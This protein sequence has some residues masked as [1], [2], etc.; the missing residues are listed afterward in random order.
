MNAFKSGQTSFVSV[1]RNQKKTSINVFDLVVGD[2]VVIKG[3]EKVPADI[4]VFRCSGIKV[5]NSPLNGETKP[6]TITTGP[7]EH[8]LKDA[9]EATNMM[10]YSTLIKDGE[11]LGIVIKTGVD[12]FMGKIADLAQSAGDGMTTLQREINDFIHLIAIV[13]VSIGLLFFILGF[14]INYPIITNFLFCIGIIVANVPEGLLSTVTICLVITAKKMQKK[15]VLVKNLQSVETLG[16][17]TCICSDK[18]GTLTQNKMKVVHL[19]YDGKIFKTESYF[20]DIEVDGRIV[21]NSVYNP[22]DIGFKYLQ[23]NAVCG[24]EDEFENQVTEEYENFKKFL[25]EEIEKNKKNPDF[26]E[27]DARDRIAK[28]LENEFQEFYKKHPEERTSKKKNASELGIMKFFDSIKPIEELKASFPESKAK[29]PFSSVYKYSCLI[30]ENRADKAPYMNDGANFYAAV[31]G[32][33][34]LLIKRCKRYMK[35]GREFPID[36]AFMERF[37]LANRTFALKGERVLGF[38]LF[39]LGGSQYPKNFEVKVRFENVKKPGSDVE[40][41]VPIANFP[42]DDLCF[43]GLVG[44]EDPPRV[45]VREAISICKRAGIKVIMVTGDQTLTAASIAEQIGIIDDLNNTPELIKHRF[46]DMTLEE[47]EKVSNV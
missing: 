5:D 20:K 39:K 12:T 38:A 3:G 40:E 14:I 33:P 17:I 25:N 37:E 19:F 43:V 22:E 6:V 13:A 1:I 30:R 41:S 44:M 15:N 8:G 21:C 35:D 26:K 46:K 32:A 18:T 7:G 27:N 11:G 34:D 31:K 9:M 23:L 10:F 16:S 28:L 24:L 42:L 2:V 47:A 29:I 36:N 45:G 4:R